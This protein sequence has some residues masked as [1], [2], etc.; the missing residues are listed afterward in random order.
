MFA[1]IMNKDARVNT[2]TIHIVCIFY[3]NLP[4][5]IQNGV[6]MAPHVIF[7]RMAM[8][9]IFICNKYFLYLLEKCRLFVF[10]SPPRYSLHKVP[11]L[12]P[13]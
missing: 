12:N 4:V 7:F 9:G 8:Q 5:L 13:R 1:R 11:Q 2:D 3:N 6:V 10:I